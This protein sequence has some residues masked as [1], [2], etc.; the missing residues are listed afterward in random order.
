MCNIRKTKMNMSKVSINPDAD[1]FAPH[2]EQIQKPLQV[3]L[4]SYS[5][6]K[7]LVKYQLSKMPKISI[8]LC[9]ICSFKVATLV[10]RY[11]HNNIFTRVKWP[12]KTTT[13][14]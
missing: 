10:S 1:I 2:T 11:Q 8:L 12:Y 3:L 14:R 9:N 4:S 7:Y 6:T 5:I 13:K